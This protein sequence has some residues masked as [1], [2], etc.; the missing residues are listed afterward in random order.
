MPGVPIE[1]PSDTVI[2]LKVIAFAPASSTPRPPARQLV[3]VHV[4]GRQIAPG[5]GDADLR[6]LEIGVDE[7]DRAQHRAA[8]RLLDA[9]DHH[10]RI[11]RVSTAADFFL[12]W[13]ASFGMDPRGGKHKHAATRN[14]GAIARGPAVRCAA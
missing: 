13:L 6:L 8:R 5:R 11:A 12:T 7:A 1:M 9:V 2:V 10:T 14:A 4:A 3:D